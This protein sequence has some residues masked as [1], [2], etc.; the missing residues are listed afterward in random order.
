MCGRYRKLGSNRTHL[1]ID[2]RHVAEQHASAAAVS[3]PPAPASPPLSPLP[4]LF[5]SRENKLQPLSK[6][7]RAAIVAL[8]KDGQ[9]NTDIAQKLDTSLATTR[10]WINHYEETKTVDDAPR[11]GRPKCTDEAMDINIAVT[12]HV[13]P[14]LTPRGIKRKLELEDVSTDTIA[15]RLDEAG[16]PARVARH[17]FQLTDEHKRKRMSFAEGY[18][19]WTDDDWCKVLFSD[20]KTFLGY[21]RSGQRWVRRPVGEAANPEYSVPEK[22][23]PVGVPA[24]ACFSAQGPGYMAMYEG[25]LKAADLR[26]ILRDYLI[27]TFNE[28]FPNAPIRWLLWDTDPGRHMS[29]LVKNFLHTQGITC[30]DF[31]P[32]SPDLNPIENLWSDMDKRMQ[33]SLADTKAEMEQLVQDTWAVTTPEQCS[34]LARSMPHRIKQ[35]IERKGAYT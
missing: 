3:P 18:Q 6:I 11:S 35:V 4:P 17:T 16:L 34:K 25:S 13:E 15:R 21:G 24:W 27:P 32:Y 14:F 22:P 29:V 1:C 12:S 20:E 19:R 28:H 31:P 5:G 8:H 2:C 23:H 10:H 26:D 33:D 9:S 7:E 30:L